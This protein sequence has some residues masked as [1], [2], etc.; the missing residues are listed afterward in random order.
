M[1]N[2]I[3]TLFGIYL[4]ALAQCSKAEDALKLLAPIAGDDL[5]PHVVASVP[6]A[7]QIGVPNT[8]VVQV[9]FDKTMNSQR[10]ISAF[11]ISPSIV[12][13]TTVVDQVLTFAPNSIFNTGTYTMTVTRDCEDTTGR[14]LAQT[15]QSSFYVGAP[16]AVAPR[17]VAVGL[18]SQGSGCS[19]LG[20]V[21]SATGGDWTA[22]RC[23]WDESLPLLNPS[24]YQFRGGDDGTSLPSACADQTTDNFRLIFNNYMIPSVTTNAISLSRISPPTTFIRLS[25]YVWSDC[26]AVAPYGCRAVTLV[27]SEQEATCNGVGSFGSAFGDFNL[28]VTAGSPAN[29]P[30]YL[31]QV[32]TS[33]QDV[34]NR[35]PASSFAFGMEGN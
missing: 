21:G 27:Y 18:E 9:Y 15:F 4:L 13:Y 24:S 35:N 8:Q 22:T 11:S 10:C 29:F 32:S 33:A 30:L 26:Q 14:D 34:N 2:K 19:V 1:K 17:V 28:S 6:V 16:L 7:S 23:F 3:S 5:G 12:G 25:T 20:S 31:L